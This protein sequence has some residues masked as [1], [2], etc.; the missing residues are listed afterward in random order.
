MGRISAHLEGSVLLAVDHEIA[1]LHVVVHERTLGAEP[2]AHADS[3]ARLEETV[4]GTRALD[5]GALLA[6]LFANWRRV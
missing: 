4:I 3:V 5:A 1:A 6:D 2:A